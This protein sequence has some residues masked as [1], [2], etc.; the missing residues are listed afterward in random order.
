MHPEA[1]NELAESIRAHGILQPLLVTEMPT[2]TGGVIYQLIA[3][4]RRLQAARLAG[5]EKVPVVIREAAP[6]QQLEYA[7]IENLQRSDLN[8]L[9]AAAAYEKLVVDFGLTQDEVAQRVG[10]SRVAVA[11][12]LRLLGLEEELKA[13]LA[14]GEMT[15][16]HARALLGI[17]EPAERRAAWRQ[18]VERNLTVRQVEALGRR[19][20]RPRRSRMAATAAGA[21]DPDRARTLDLLRKALGTKVDI[22][23]T[24]DAGT[25]NIY[26][27]SDEQL[28]A[29]VNY[30]LGA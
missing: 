10:K 5:L 27:Y 9:E 3:G 4:E 19:A 29:I 26:F 14:R 18:I 16:G 8:P 22:Q 15:E 21:G 30:L 7:L 1:L 13:S 24:G 12:A 2:E 20:G 6:Q 25:V 28:E 11:N 23:R 17:P